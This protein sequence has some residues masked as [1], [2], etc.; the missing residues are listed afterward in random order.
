MARGLRRRWPVRAAVAGGLLVAFVVPTQSG[1]DTVPA[2]RSTTGSGSATATSISE[3]E[4]RALLDLYAAESALERARSAQQ[5]L[6]QRA[7]GLERSAAD[8]S[9]QRAIVRRSLAGTQRRIA[10]L[11]RALY[12]QG[13]PDAI[14][15]V[16]G[17][18]S[19]DEVLDG[20]D[21][22]RR[23]TR[24]NERLS[25]EARNRAR[26]L[27]RIEAHLARARVA[28]S[29][30]QRDSASSVSALESARA[31]RAATVASLRRQNALS[32]QRI[33]TLQAQA[34]AAE[35]KSQ[36]LAA[37]TTPAPQALPSTAAGTTAATPTATPVSGTR[38]LVVDAV[39]YHLPGRTASGLPTGV[40]VIAVDP[41]VIPLGTK[42]FVPGYG[43]AVA[44]DTGTAVRGNIIDLWMPSTPQAQAWGRRTVTITIYG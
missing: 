13:Q 21:A 3:H 42:V 39:A 9:A 35:Q 14:S 10:A 1:A 18:S 26:E 29:A 15:I 31:S 24:S 8:A 38:T 7:A 44:A 16:L 40:G 36:A 33:A 4:R 17:A 25:A 34:Q 32:V 19:L 41:S 2:Q 27:D 28:L 6:V 23:A 11:L 30:A 12:V 37:S 5:R 43:A 22:L 20:I